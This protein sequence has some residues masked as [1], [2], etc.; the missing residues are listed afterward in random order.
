MA[1]LNFTAQT[2]APTQ[3]QA[4]G[5]QPVWPS[6]CTLSPDQRSLLGTNSMFLGVLDTPAKVI[7][8]W[9]LADIARGE[10]TRAQAALTENKA[11]LRAQQREAKEAARVVKQQVA[12][13]ARAKWKA[14]I[15]NRRLRIVELDAEVKA[16]HDAYSTARADLMRP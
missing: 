2:N 15:E 12:D 11:E 9:R 5:L 3:P 8:H 13:A 6:D 10:Q 14:A 7:E 1:E 4:P 16:A